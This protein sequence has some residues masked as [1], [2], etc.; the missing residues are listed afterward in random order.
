ML[1]KEMVAKALPASLKSSVTQ[2]LVDTVNNVVSDPLIA[3]Q[4]RENFLSYSHVLQDG[5]YK[6]ED[7]LNAVQ[8][9]SYKLMN[10]SNQDAYFLTFPQR[11]AALVAKGASKKDISAYVAAYNKNQLVN[12]ILEQSI[13]PS[14]VLNQDKYQDAINVQADLMMNAQSEKV[15]C[16]AANSLLTHL[17]KPKEAGFQLNINAQESSGMNEL[18]DLLKNLAQ[19]SIQNIEQGQSI[20]EI[21]G[22]RIFTQ[23]SG[24]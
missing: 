17:S 15:R 18:R 12:K 7:Y 3:E 6:M 1:T 8:Y 14:W 2:Q 10:K 9:V 4:V 11:H 5:K 22:Q 20:K 16:D 19:Q 24:Q 23:E 21:T 13:I